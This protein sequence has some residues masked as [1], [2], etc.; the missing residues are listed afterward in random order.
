[1]FVDQINEYGK[2]ALPPSEMLH[3]LYSASA[4]P[5]S[6]TLDRG[7]SATFSEAKLCRLVGLSLRLAVCV[8]AVLS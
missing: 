5:G 2:G 4:G 1:M 7:D 3:A 8:K 6:G